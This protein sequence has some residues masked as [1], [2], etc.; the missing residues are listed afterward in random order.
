MSSPKPT[1]LDGVTFSTASPP[2]NNVGS[3]GQTMTDVIKTMPCIAQPR[4]IGIEIQ[5]LLLTNPDTDFILRRD[6][7]VISIRRVTDDCSEQ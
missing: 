7:Q 1:S 4:Q 3:P 6:G 5:T 2:F